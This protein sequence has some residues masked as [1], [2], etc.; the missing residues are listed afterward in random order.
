[1]NIRY[2]TILIVFV[3]AA[4]YAFHSF[5][6]D[7]DGGDIVNVRLVHDDS[8]V[9]PIRLDIPCEYAYQNE[10]H[11]SMF[12]TYDGSYKSITISF[13]RDTLEP[14]MPWHEGHP[15]AKGWPKHE[16]RLELRRS[17][18]P[19]PAKTTKEAK[20]PYR[21]LVNNAPSEIADKFEIYEAKQSVFPIGPYELYPKHQ[22]E[23]GT[24]ISC[25]NSEECKILKAR[26]YYKGMGLS[27]RVWKEQL[28]EW[29]TIEADSRK[30]IDEFIQN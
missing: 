8:N 29:Q 10:H 9:E 30:L 18:N 27:Y 23:A 4:Y 21:K 17:S 3:G 14:T 25:I 11:Q 28:N 12:P 13:F 24:I 1:M 15:E 22:S 16:I 19:T 20:L 6:Y 5:A 26:T 7:C 2:V